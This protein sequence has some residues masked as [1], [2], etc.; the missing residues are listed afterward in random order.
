MNL[1]T[2]SMLLTFVGSASVSVFANRPNVILID[3]GYG[4][5]GCH[6]YCTD[7]WFDEA[8]QFVE[9]NQGHPF[10]LY[11]ATNAPHGPYR[12]D[13]KW[14]KPYQTKV[15]WRG[16]AEFYGMIATIDHNL[17][18]LRARLEELDLARNTLL[19]FMTDNGMARNRQLSRPT[20]LPERPSWKRGSTMKR[21]NRAE[22]ISK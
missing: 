16:A 18:L 9:R 5:L 22:P 12:V 1:P 17:G 13:P 14:R 8:L 4:D 2:V 11:L 21:V 3:Q 20:C 10:L 6:G 7:V 19:I 15:R